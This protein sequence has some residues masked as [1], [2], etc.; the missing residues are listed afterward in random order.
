MVI[1]DSQI[2]TIAADS[3]LFPT[4]L[5]LMQKEAVYGSYLN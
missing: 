2:H 1:N 4:A 5:I 3:N